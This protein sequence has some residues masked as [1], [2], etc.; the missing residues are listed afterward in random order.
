MQLQP[1]PPAVSGSYP[2]M[3]TRS[4]GLQ[5]AGGLRGVTCRFP[6]ELKRE[7]YSMSY[8]ASGA[9]IA[10]SSNANRFLTYSVMEAAISIASDLIPKMDKKFWSI[11]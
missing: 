11:K 9:E 2:C 6:L 7:K 8:R 3:T 5:S 1:I 4:P 10:T